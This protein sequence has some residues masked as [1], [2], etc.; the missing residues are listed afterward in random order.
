MEVTLGN[1]FGALL[2]E[3]QNSYNPNEFL[4]IY[5]SSLPDTEEV[6]FYCIA[7]LNKF[8]AHAFPAQLDSSARK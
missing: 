5:S 2:K 1:E 7:E 4:F 8:Q 6:E 3:M